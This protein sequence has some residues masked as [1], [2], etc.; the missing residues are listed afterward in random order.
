MTCDDCCCCCGGRITTRGA[1]SSVGDRSHK[2]Y[3]AT[4]AK[5]MSARAR[6]AFL[7]ATDKLRARPQI[8]RIVGAKRNESAQTAER[9]AKSAA[10]KTRRRRCSRSADCHAEAPNCAMRR[11]LVARKRKS[12]GPRRAKNSGARF[13]FCSASARACAREQVAR[14][15]RFGSDGGGADAVERPSV[16]SDD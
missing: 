11:R 7:R 14:L 8:T 5:I 6:E 16:C 10:R 15:R 1:R 2:L 13:G 4:S 12:C 3:A 9:P